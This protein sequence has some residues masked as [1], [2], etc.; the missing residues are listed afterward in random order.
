MRGL[1]A[2]GALGGLALAEKAE[3]LAQRD[4]MLSPRQRTCRTPGWIPVCPGAFPCIPPGGV[5][6]DDGITYVMPPETCPDGTSPIATAVTSGA[7]VPSITSAPPVP[8]TLPPVTEYE[9]YTWTIRVTW[10]YYYYTYFA[11]SASLTSSETTYLTTGSI[12]ASNDAAATSLIASIGASITSSVKAQT[13]TPTLGSVPPSTYTP[14]STPTPDKT[15]PTAM[16][17]PTGNA[18]VPVPPV[19]PPTSRP[20]EFTGAAARVGAVAGAFFG[21]AAVMAGA[22]GMLVPAVLMVCL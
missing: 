17:Y 13:A 18:T 12:T 16:P 8:T 4:A 14:A 11:F 2:L 3:P 7:A 15:A 5:C 21:S 10:Y 20:T 22:V 1:L 19:V 9:W 6:C